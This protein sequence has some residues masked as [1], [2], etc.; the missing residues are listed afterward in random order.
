L[1]IGEDD[2]AG[3]IDND[4]GIWGRFQEASTRFFIELEHGSI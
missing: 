4:H 1:G 2:F 3:M